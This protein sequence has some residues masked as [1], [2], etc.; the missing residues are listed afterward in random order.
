MIRRRHLGIRLGDLAVRT[1]QHGHALR[2]RRIGIGRAE[3]DGRRLVE[4]AAKI[5]RKVEFLP[6]RPIVLGGVE[7]DAQNYRILVGK[8]LDSITE[9]FSFDRSP[10]GIGFRIPPEQNVFSRELIERHGISVL[11]RQRE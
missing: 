6:E 4:V 7:T 5:V 11:V 1:D 10:G 9:P 2:P 8:R 3:G